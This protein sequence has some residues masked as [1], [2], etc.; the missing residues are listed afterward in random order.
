[1]IDLS[2]ATD[3]LTTFNGTS[4]STTQGGFED[5]DF[6][7]VNGAVTATAAAAGSNITGGTVA[8][9]IT[10]GAGNDTLS[11]GAGNDTLTGG[12]GTDS[13]VGGTGTNRISVQLSTAG[14]W[15]D[16]VTGGSGALDTL[17]V[18]GAAISTRAIINLAVT[19][20]SNITQNL[21][22][23]LDASGVTAYGITSTLGN[24]AVTAYG[25]EQADSITAG[26]GADTIY[27]GGGADS[28][29]G[30]GGAESMVA[31]EGADTIVMAAGLTTADV[32]TGGGGTDTL[33]ITDDATTTDLDNVT[34]V[35]IITV[36]MTSASSYTTVNALVA[37]GSTLTVNQTGAFGLTFNGAAET[38][39]TFIIDA[40]G[41]GAHVITG[42]SLADTIST[43][44]VASTITGGL[45]ID[46]IT[47][48][49]ANA[50]VDIL[51]Q[52]TGT[53][54]GAIT[55]DTV[56]NFV[57]GSDIVQFDRSDLF[58]AATLVNIAGNG[59]TA[60]GATINASAATLTTV[61]AAFSQG[62]A[63]TTT[64]YIINTAVAYTAATLGTALSTGGGVAVTTN[65]AWTAGVE[66]WL[67][68]YDDNANT[69][70]GLVQNAATITTGSTGTFTVTN[71]I[72][73]TGM[74]S[75]T[76][77]TTADFQLIA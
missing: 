10:G 8:D 76:S 9:S 36:V 64:A 61:T 25:T 5:A 73:L 6:S 50:A 72:Q 47:L 58:L 13:I 62:T 2:A 17:V 54:A 77:F 4:N 11:G 23:V 18:T 30:G 63:A 46:V 66:G 75:A 56:T 1:V 34:E 49:A 65:G 35:E 41:A 42:G 44:S 37:S 45:G 59:A 51:I 67:V 29:T 40:A 24:N 27:G 14:N 60:I 39:G 12:A 22:D 33:T 55:A 32:V 52:T 16:T 21:I 15:D 26:G 31:G 28:I 71:L 57:G 68:I 48:G 43:S 74:A 7:T 20:T 19:A 3:Q 70:V 38:N 53:A 69:Y